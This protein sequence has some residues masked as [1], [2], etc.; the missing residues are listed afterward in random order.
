MLELCIAHNK[1]YTKKGWQTP[2]K[3][4][5]VDIVDRIKKPTTITVCDICE[6][7]Y[8]EQYIFLGGVAQ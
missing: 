8:N 2:T 3:Y 6:S 5:A 4:K 1:I 7:V